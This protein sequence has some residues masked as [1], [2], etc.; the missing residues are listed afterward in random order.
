MAYSPPST[1]YIP[2][3]AEVVKADPEFARKKHWDIEY[4]ASS[5]GRSLWADPYK[6]G[7]YDTPRKSVSVNYAGPQTFGVGDITGVGSD[8]VT[9]I[10][11]NAA[12]GVLTTRTGAQMFGDISGAVAGMGYALRVVNF[13]GLSP[14]IFMPD[15]S[16]IMRDADWKGQIILRDSINPGNFSD[17][18]VQFPNATQALIKRVSFNEP[19]SAIVG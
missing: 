13:G 14:L 3:L 16:I 4:P 18:Q 5:E 19:Y 2:W 9:T 6:R 12:P 11:D 15:P 10:S 17:Y 7:A 8:F 1:I